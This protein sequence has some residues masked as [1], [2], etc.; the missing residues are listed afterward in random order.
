MATASSR[1]RCLRECRVANRTAH[2]RIER[3]EG[4]REVGEAF[5]Q[6]GVGEGIVDLFSSEGEEFLRELEMEQ[7]Q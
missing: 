6:V 1:H 7:C 4:G 5:E 2:R 3:L